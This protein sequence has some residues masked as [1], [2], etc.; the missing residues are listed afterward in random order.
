MGG[1]G[2]GLQ[3]LHYLGKR[4][5]MIAHQHLFLPSHWTLLFVLIGQVFLG[6]T[7]SSSDFHWSASAILAGFS[8]TLASF[9]PSHWSVLVV[10][11]GQFLSFFWAFLL[12]L[13]GRYSQHSSCHPIRSVALLYSSLVNFFRPYCSVFFSLKSFI[14]PLSFHYIFRSPLVAWSKILTLVH[15]P[16]SL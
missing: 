7:G 12:V 4:G 6:V 9:P 10:V 15:V 13:I 11:I 3:S 1:G 8:F 2:G 5:N 16:Y 14:L